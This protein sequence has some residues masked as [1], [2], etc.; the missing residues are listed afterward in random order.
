[1]IIFPVYASE[2]DDLGRKFIF[3]YRIWLQ[4][5]SLLVFVVSLWM[6][7]MFHVLRRLWQPLHGRRQQPSPGTSPRRCFSAKFV[8]TV[9]LICV[10][11]APIQKRGCGDVHVHAVY[12]GAGEVGVFGTSRI[13]STYD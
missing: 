9:R 13:G 2:T 5:F 3:F 8:H 7:K 1:M 10:R 4:R 6:K 11:N 12:C